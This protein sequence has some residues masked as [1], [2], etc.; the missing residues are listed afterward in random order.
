MIKSA[1]AQAWTMVVRL[2][3]EGNERLGRIL[4][5]VIL[6]RAGYTFF[7]EVSLSSLIA[8]KGYGYFDAMANIMREE[9][10]GDLTYFLEY[11]LELL[12][13]AVDE[14][15]L[16]MSMKEEE[17]RVAEQEMAHTPLSASVPLTG[18]DPEPAVEEV[19]EEEEN[20]TA[21]GSAESAPEWQELI[22]TDPP[23]LPIPI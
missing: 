19:R 18:Q 15:R 11:Y 3:S 8:R 22:G 20:P 21:E 2:F 7:D 16:R 17:N 13:R 6:V 1:V 5:S 10:G 4:S 23:T 9:N 12:S 14:R